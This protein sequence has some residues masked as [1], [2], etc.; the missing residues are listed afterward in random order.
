MT[1]EIF[2]IKAINKHGVKFDYKLV[3]EIVHNKEY[4]NIICPI[5]G[6]F[7][8]QV[9]KH[10]EGSGCVQ[11]ARERFRLSKNEYIEKA[12]EVHSNKYD[13]SNTVYKSNKLKLTIICPLHGEFMQEANAHLRGQ[14][15]PHCRL[16]KLRTIAVS[17]RLTNAEFLTKL[18]NKHPEFNSKYNYDMTEYTTYHALIHVTC[19]LHGNFQIR[20]SNHMNG[21]GCPKC[22]EYGFNTGKPAILYYLKING[23]QAY[24]IGITNRT[25][26]ER[27]NNNALQQIEILATRYYEVGQDAYDAEQQVLKDYVEFKY[28]GPDILKDG[29]TE[30]FIKDVLSM[31]SSKL[32]IYDTI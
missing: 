19:L 18:F 14:G 1:K 5:H 28:N 25:I 12:S 8:Q 21:R 26:E 4:I 3:Q 13:Y 30:L 7:K 31:D 15:C 6:E 2:I 22:A 17:N 27:F 11:C 10:L 9:R 23:G 16:D 20:A 24:K 32:N 29:N